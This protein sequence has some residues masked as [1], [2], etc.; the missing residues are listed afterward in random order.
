MTT[1]CFFHALQGPHPLAQGIVLGGEM[2]TREWKVD[3]R[4]RDRYKEE[5]GRSITMSNSYTEHN[6]NNLTNERRWAN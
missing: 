5:K 3:T 1:L 2:D 4:T 6:I